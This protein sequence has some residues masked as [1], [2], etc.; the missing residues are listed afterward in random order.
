MLG[1]IIYN[2]Y[3]IVWACKER[4]QYF[5]YTRTLLKMKPI[6]VLIRAAVRI[7]TTDTV[8]MTISQPALTC[9]I[10]ESKLSLAIED[11]GI[12]VGI[13]HTE[14]LLSLI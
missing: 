12:E 8:T 14:S 1:L 5:R 10:A 13:D 6:D 4:F 3:G 7:L 2:C 11:C 9:Q